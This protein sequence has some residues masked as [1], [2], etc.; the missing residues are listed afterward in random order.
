[1]S[2]TDFTHLSLRNTPY[3]KQSVTVANG[4]T[5]TTL[6]MTH[7][8]K[9]KSSNVIY[10]H[11]HKL[12]RKCYIGITV[13][14]AGDRWFSGSAYKMNARFGPALIKHGWESFDTYILAF[15]E[16]RDSLN[17]AE[18]SAI[19]AAGGHKSKFTYNLSPGGDM[20]AEN[21]KPLIGV[22][23]PTGEVREFKSGSDASRILD[24]GSTDYPMVIARGEGSSVQDWWFRFKDDETSQPPKVWGEPLRIQKLKDQISK[25]L[26]AINYETNETRHFATQYE[27]AAVLGIQQ[28]SISL[29]LT[30]Q[31]YSA[32]GWWF[33]FEDDDREMPKSFG[34]KAIREK[35]DITVY[36]TQ[37][38]T[39]KKQVFRN[40]TVADL[41]LGIYKGAAAAVASG[42]RASAG[43]WWFSYDEK[44]KPPTEFKGA[45]VAIARSKPVVAINLVTG[46]E[47]KY[48]SAKLAGA[49]LGISRAA[50]SKVI[51]GEL[52]AAKGYLFRF[53]K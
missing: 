23:L 29:V 40:C 4:A 18:I 19:K 17:V 15:I 8:E 13:Q 45:L 49:E 43:D 36:A 35:R 28:S 21:D 31:S 51:K 2:S 3:S 32:D 42:E 26:S 50:I 25:P 37:L 22:Y 5:F 12:S 11:V 48:S 38:F 46:S 7:D 41:E 44:T 24:L 1:M 34:F 10:M 47:Q 16:D 14:S 27:T 20:V 33:R 9:I 39:G 53:F 52:K 30:G 6:I